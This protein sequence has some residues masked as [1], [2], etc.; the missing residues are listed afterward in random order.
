MILFSFFLLFVNP[1]RKSVSKM[2][3]GVELNALVNQMAESG[4]LPP[5][6]HT[7]TSKVFFVIFGTRQNYAKVRYKNGKIKKKIQKFIWY[8]GGV[9]KDGR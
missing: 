3:S 5:A 8:I 1:D 4:S 7:S 2:M 6:F 9:Y